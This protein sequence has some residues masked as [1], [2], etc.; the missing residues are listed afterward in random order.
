MGCKLTSQVCG[1]D[2]YGTAT[3]TKASYLT[4]EASVQADSSGARGGCHTAGAVYE[5]LEAPHR[6]LRVSRLRCGILYRDLANG[7]AGSN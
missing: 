5:I 4:P 6:D 1:T 7:T 2:E 3:E